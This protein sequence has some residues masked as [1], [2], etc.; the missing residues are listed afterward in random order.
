MAWRDRARRRTG[1]PGAGA[2]TGAD[3]AGPGVD[4]PRPG[5]PGGWDGGWRQ[6]SAPRLTVSRAPL[7]VSDGLV[8]RAGLAA[9]RDPSFDTGLAHGVL[10]SAP[11]GLVSGV[12]HP[13][14]GTAKAA[15]S[16]GGPLLLRALAPV[17]EEDDSGPTPGAGDI[18]STAVRPAGPELSQVQRHA[19][20]GERGTERTD[21]RSAGPTAE[22]GTSGTGNTGRTAP[23]A[24]G[25]A[26]ERR[27]APSVQRRTPEGGSP[28][29]RAPGGDATSRT[30]PDS[31]DTSSR[32]GQRDDKG[33]R[34]VPAPAP[35]NEPPAPT[36][37]EA[38]VQRALVAGESLA[39]LDGPV[40][41]GRQ[42]D[43]PG[44]DRPA[45][46]TPARFPLVR[47]I[48]VVPGSISGTDPVRPSDMPGGPASRSPRTDVGSARARTDAGD[49]ARPGARTI[50]TASSAPGARTA[51]GGRSGAGASPAPRTDAATGAGPSA[52][53]GHRPRAG[54]GRSHPRDQGAPAPLVRPRPAGR[55]L[56]VSRDATGPARRIAALA[57][58]P[59]TR[60][61]ERG[62]APAT[63]ATEPHDRPAERSPQT[64]PTTPG[65]P[66]LGA[67]LPQMPPTAVQLSPTSGA[68]TTSETV[69]PLDLPVV[70]SRTDSPPE[71]P[72][73]T[74]R[75]APGTAAPG[76]PAPA[77]VN[78]PARPP[79]RTGLGAPLS[80]LPASA[81]PTGR[82]E[83]S[84][85]PRPGGSARPS[86]ASVQR[87]LAQ[88]GNPAQPRDPAQT[89]QA[90]LLGGSPA[91]DAAPPTSPPPAN[92]TAPPTPFLAPSGHGGTSG[93]G[94]TDAVEGPGTTGI[95][96]AVVQRS[97]SGRATPPQDPAATPPRA[98]ASAP[99]ATGTP[100]GPATPGAQA[101]EQPGA[102]PLPRP[103][104]VR[105]RGTGP[106]GPV[107]LV[108]ARAV[109][110]SAY[111]AAPGAGAASTI[112]PTV[113]LL[114]ARPLS[115]STQA[116]SG[117]ALPAP[118]P[119][120]R[121]VVVAR[122]SQAG[123][124][125]RDGGDAPAST[126]R[127]PADGARHIQ[128]V[129][130][131]PAPGSGSPVTHV[132]RPASAAP[133]LQSAPHASVPARPL[134]V[135]A[136]QGQLPP[137][138]PTFAATPGLPARQEPHRT[139]PVVR[140]AARVV[141]R[142]GAT[143][144]SSGG[145]PAASSMSTAGTQTTAAT[146]T[147]TSSTATATGTGTSAATGAG[148][149]ANRTTASTGTQT[150]PA[151]GIDLDDLA[152]RL[153]DPV[154]RLL[155]TELRRGRERTGHPT[156]RRR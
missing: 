8:F 54:A 110:G 136:P 102:T 152:R 1:R 131:A 87:A 101:S 74:P 20:A 22:R 57:P 142:D 37:A 29:P 116:A 78:G 51:A 155:R 89:P 113:R 108:V 2:S 139:A 100:A 73:A 99:P 140:P 150:S 49:G 153:L 14:T 50:M 44:A 141:Q 52:G 60:A 118:R 66:P 129:T 64:G 28:P 85:R 53:R 13:V 19:R 114:S 32:P 41:P 84:G 4:E 94:A 26:A 24:P 38:P 127:P 104:G 5:V 70:Q 31:T 146:S 119:G 36:P 83:R 43:A 34:T 115:V 117:P 75:S 103:G 133:M 125:V 67:P 156:D 39:V 10:P 106:G 62:P 98:G 137:V 109:G 72:S 105:H 23:R 138:Q 120:G 33:R 93:P 76:T 144:A 68:Y 3:A 86:R 63:A 18:Q 7:A 9:W 35:G 143:P 40:P 21:E 128:R 148:T 149:V 132:V 145:P 27:D 97:A 30:S 65:R 107:P 59:A 11:T 47:R 82:G 154:S 121:P 134:P 56:I 135:S 96:G 45:S 122:W 147:R 91:A 90:P 111:S 42:A 92:R 95:P 77:A 17:T 6:V 16:G 12:A 71:Q 15:R 88:P 112:R 61:S 126:P 123:P 48:A 80:A 79:V 69:R 55:S 151:P 25:G 46:A 81:E 124:S 130:G 58:A